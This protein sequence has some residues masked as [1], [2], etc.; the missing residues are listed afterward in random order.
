VRKGFVFG[1][2]CSQNIDVVTLFSYR[3][4]I[5]FYLPSLFAFVV[6]VVVVV[7]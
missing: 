6:V 3:F 5:S 1:C 4:F 7:V 2:A